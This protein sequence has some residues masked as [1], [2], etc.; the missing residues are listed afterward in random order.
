MD[1]R[2][3]ACLVAASFLGLGVTAAATGAHAKPRSADITVTAVDP[4]LQRRVSYA[5][6]N[7]A[8][9]SGQRA[10]HYRIS[11]TAG[12]LCLDINGWDDGSCKTFAINS[13]RDQ[14]AQA[15]ARAKRQM[16]GL[17]VGPPIAIGMVIA[18]R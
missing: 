13:T 8:Y 15:I 4:A 6:L 1:T 10:L 14:V 2:K 17:A 9:K 3:I 7:L 5:D 18:V 11:Y 16:A 12:A